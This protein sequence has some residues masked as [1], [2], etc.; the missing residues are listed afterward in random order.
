[1]RCGGSDTGVGMAAELGGWREG[2]L[3]KGGKR[4]Q[5]V[6]QL[7]ISRSQGSKHGSLTPVPHEVEWRLAIPLSRRTC[8]RHQ[9]VIYR[10]RNLPWAYSRDKLASLRAGFFYALALAEGQPR[11]KIM[12]NE[13]PQV[14]YSRS[15]AGRGRLRLRWMTRTA[16]GQPASKPEAAA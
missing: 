15:K 16:I 3:R 4:S 2:W 11:D 5:P 7:L 1:M 14:R 9:R 13:P 6:S 12:D 10:R 8:N